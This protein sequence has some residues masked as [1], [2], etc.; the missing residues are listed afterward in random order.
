MK[1][2]AKHRKIR[3]TLASVG[4]SKAG[5]PPTRQASNSNHQAPGKVQASCF[6]LQTRPRSNLGAWSF[7]EAWALKLGVF[8]FTQ[9]GQ[10]CQ[11]GFAFGGFFAFAMTTGQFDTLVKHR[12]F[13]H[14]VV[15]G[16][17]SRND[18]VLGR[19]GRN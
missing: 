19:L 4:A 17:G 12:T 6:M 10:R 14:A 1:R 7:P 8:L 16:A 13:K 9:P 2:S 11:G 3:A 18:A 5:Q 15:I